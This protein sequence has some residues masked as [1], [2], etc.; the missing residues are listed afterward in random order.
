L[1]SDPGLKNDRDHLAAHA[2]SNAF[3]VSL[4][5]GTGVANAA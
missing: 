3:I 4:I 5:A 1:S 2:L